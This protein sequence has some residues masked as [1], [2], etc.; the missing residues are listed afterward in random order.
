[1]SV[2]LTAAHELGRLLMPYKFG[3]EEMLTKLSIIRQELSYRGGS[4]IEH[5]SSRLKSPDSILEKARRR[6]VALTP[7]AVSANIFDIAGIRVICSFIPDAYDVLGMLTKQPDVTLLEIEDYIAQPKPSGYR[8][9]H[10]TI[11]V[12]VFMSERTQLVPVELQLRTAA[13]D[14]WA[15]VEHKLFYKY[16]REVPP[17]MR[18]ELLDAAKVAHELDLRMAELRRELLEPGEREQ[19]RDP[20]AT[21]AGAGVEGAA[22]LGG[23]FAH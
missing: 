19:R 20:A 11:E 3:L 18:R 14:F 10:A 13:M 7:E 8:S 1:L 9:L 23:P 6:D 2:D 16:D 12:P 22:E 17:D 15:G 21:G 4:P 5:V